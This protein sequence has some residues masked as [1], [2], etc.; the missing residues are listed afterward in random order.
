[1]INRWRGTASMPLTINSK[2]Q[3]QT[4][5]AKSLMWKL[6]VDE[7]NRRKLHHNT[8]TTTTNTKHRRIEWKCILFFSYTFID[9]SSCS[10][11]CT[12]KHMRDFCC[13]WQS[14][15]QQQ[16][17]QVVSLTAPSD[18]LDARLVKGLTRDDKLKCARISF[19]HVPANL[20][21]AKSQ[22]LVLCVLT[23]AHWL[24]VYSAGRNHRNCVHKYRPCIYA[25]SRCCAHI[26]VWPALR[27]I[28]Q[29]KRSFNF[30]RPTIIT[31]L[32][33]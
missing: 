27:S 9:P 12:L 25:F 13:F 15:L 4:H 1:M 26:P 3:C 10:F 29:L 28:E 31:T 19:Q 2:M 32:L 24:L 14:A 18:N 33:Q 11:S 16:Q 5:T 21:V 23:Y 6:V 30:T 17:Q 8:T 22:A 7:R 20:G